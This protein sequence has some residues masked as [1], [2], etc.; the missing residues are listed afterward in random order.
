MKS[1][2]L[3]LVGLSDNWMAAAA[4]AAAAAP[5]VFVPFPL[6]LDVAVAVAGDACLL[7]EEDVEVE[8]VEL[9]ETGGGSTEWPAFRRILLMLE[10]EGMFGSPIR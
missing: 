8:E 4:A 3:P 5:L 10:T 6:L 1:R 2:I 9:D 7:D